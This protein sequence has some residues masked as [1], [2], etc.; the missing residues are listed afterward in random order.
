MTFGNRFPKEHDCFSYYWDFEASDWALWYDKV[1][2]YQPIPIGGGPGET[3]FADLFVPT[4]DSSRLTF[5]M[6]TLARKGRY[7]ML[8]GS[9]S[10]KTSIISQY[11][12]SLDKDTDGF[13]TQ[14][15]NM[16]YYTD[17]AILQHLNDGG[18]SRYDMPEY[19]IVM[20]AF[21]LTASGKILKRELAADL[22]AGKFTPA[23]C[24]FAA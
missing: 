23:P 15:I 6:N 4:S 11:L 20:E 8:V 24:R 7:T 5:L 13:L 10:G 18:L 19:F 16:S 17:S 12:N 14:T 3:P 21:P 22:I 1:P 9:G 2:E